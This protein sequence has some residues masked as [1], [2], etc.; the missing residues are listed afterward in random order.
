MGIIW[1]SKDRKS[2]LHFCLGA[3]SK[4]DDLDN[5]SMGETEASVSL[6]TDE[7]ANSLMQKYSSQSHTAP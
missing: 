7:A 5:A 6:L 1:V 3:Y 4:D 2:P